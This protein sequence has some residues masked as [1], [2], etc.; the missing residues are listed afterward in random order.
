MIE[1]TVGQRRYH[2]RRRRQLMEHHGWRENYSV[3]SSAS[4]ERN[5]YR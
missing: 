1:E 3:I 4:F 2:H 5:P